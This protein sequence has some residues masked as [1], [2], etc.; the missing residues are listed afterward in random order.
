MSIACAGIMLCT[1]EVAS[2]VEFPL[3]ELV[4]ILTVDDDSFSAILADVAVDRR[5]IGFG[6]DGDDGVLVLGIELEGN[7]RNDCGSS[8][9]SSLTS[10]RGDPCSGD[11]DDGGLKRLIGTKD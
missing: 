10:I 7:R 8:F 9:L 11:I 4:V 1:E 2:V 5:G 3:L 6:G